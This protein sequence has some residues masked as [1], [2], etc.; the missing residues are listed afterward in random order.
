[1]NPFKPLSDYPSVQIGL[2]VIAYALLGLWLGK[3]AFLMLSPLLAAAIARPLMAL[4]SNMRHAIRWQVWAPVMGQHYVFK[5]ISIRVLED[6]RRQRWV[7]LSDVWKVTGDPTSERILSTVY[8]GQLKMMG[9]PLEAHLKDEALVTHLGT[10]NRLQA[11]KLRT[12]VERT[13]V[14]PGRELRRQHHLV[15]DD[16]D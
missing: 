4:A 16:D 11:I 14:M 6:E 3:F 2:C 12:W 1:M 7:N 10:Q 9:K 5:D 15:P 13:I 8:P